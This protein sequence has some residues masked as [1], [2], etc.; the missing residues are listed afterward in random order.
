[1][2]DADKLHLNANAGAAPNFPGTQAVIQDTW[3]AR[4]RAQSVMD[5]FV[6]TDWR[7]RFLH[8]GT[9]IERPVLPLIRVNDRRPGDLVKY[10]K[11]RGDMETFTIN[12]MM[13]VAYHIDVEDSAFSLRNLES[14]SNQEAM[15]AM[16]EH[17]DLKFFA[18]VPFKCDPANCGANAGVVSGLY[19]LG[20]ITAPVKLFA[21]DTEA[22]AAGG[23]AAHCYSATRYVTM[24]TGA[25]KEWPAAKAGALRIG[26]PTW[27]QTLLINSELKHAD[28]MGDQLSVLRKGTDYIGD[29]DGA[30]I[31]GCNQLPMWASETVDGTSLPKRFLVM[32]GNNKAI[33]FADEFQINEK[34]K[35]K[36]EYGD[37]YRSLDIYDWFADYPELFGY[38]VVTQ[39]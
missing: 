23:R 9:T 8:H 14:A 27:I 19:D 10:Q 37:F 4:V 1:M 11:L 32:I 30:S 28:A 25:M 6:S 17:R 7:G 39:G 20:T 16:A 33:Q 34:L 5:K 12:R 2:A 21:T 13:D 38:G 35:D 31:I 15:A 29:I 36:D 22:N 18:D 24:L 26:L 3:R